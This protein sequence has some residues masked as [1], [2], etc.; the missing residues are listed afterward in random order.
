MGRADSPLISD[1]NSLNKQLK[2]LFI[3]VGDKDSLLTA[4][5]PFE[6]VLTQN[7]IKR[8]MRKRSS[9]HPCVPM[10]GAPL[11]PRCQSSTRPMI[12]RNSVP[13]NV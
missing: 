6:Q 1:A 9:V 3:G 10:G 7:G 5:S 12:P 2:L 8:V 4:N 13:E 11:F